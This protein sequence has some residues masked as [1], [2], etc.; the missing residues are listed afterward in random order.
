MTRSEDIN[1]RNFDK[2]LQ[3]ALDRG[4]NLPSYW[5]CVKMLVFWPMQ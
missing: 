5:Q 2:Y 1:I 4:V 3:F